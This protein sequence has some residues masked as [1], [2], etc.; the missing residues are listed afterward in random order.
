MTKRNR[1]STIGSYM[2]VFGSAFIPT[3][4]SAAQPE[5]ARQHFAA[6]EQLVSLPAPAAKLPPRRVVSF[7]QR[8][9]NK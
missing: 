1:F 7:A 6:N 5:K 2:P 4:P 9:R 3:D 8:R